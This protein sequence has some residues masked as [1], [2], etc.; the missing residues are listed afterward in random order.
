MCS[1]RISYLSVVFS[2][3]FPFIQFFL[4]LIVLTQILY[5]THFRGFLGLNECFRFVSRYLGKAVLRD[6]SQIIA[7]V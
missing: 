2:D 5:D 4:N 3:I 6:D 7:I 1:D